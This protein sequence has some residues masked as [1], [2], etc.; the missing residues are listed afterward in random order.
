ML[1]DAKSA[2]KNTLLTL[3]ITGGMIFV[4]VGVVFA[5]TS[6]VLILA[7]ALPLR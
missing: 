7:A 4:T 2:T 1:G 5:A 3:M 6:G